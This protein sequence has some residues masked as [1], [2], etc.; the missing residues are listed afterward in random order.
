VISTDPAPSLGDALARP[1]GRSPRKIPLG[2]RWLHAVEIDAPRALEH[3]L[4]ARRDALER[5]AVRGTWL[6][7]EDVSGLLRLS[8]PGI[9]ELAALMEIARLAATGRYDLVVVDTAPTGH[10]LRML[11]MPGTFRAIAGV[12]DAMQAKHRVMVEALRGGWMPDSEDA[13]IAAI[14]REGQDLAALL[15][16]PAKVR[17]SWVTLPEPMAI[18][19]TAD[20]AAALASAGIPLRDIIVNRITPR[21]DRPCGWCDARRVLERRAIGELT[22]RLPGLSLASIAARSTEPRGARA[23]AGIGAELGV[24][25][26]RGAARLTRTPLPGA[27]AATWRSKP[28]GDGG[29]PLDRFMSDG[30]RLILFGGKGGVGKT[31]CAAAVAIAMAVHRP[32]ARVLLMSTDPA[33]SLADVFGSPLSDD[34]R[35]VTAAP[36]NLAAREIDAAARFRDVRD[37]YA[38][39]IDALFERLSRGSSGGVGLDAGHDKEVMQRLID[40]APPGVDELAAVIDVTDALEGGHGRGG[41]DLVVMDTAPSG[42]ALRLLQM[43]ALVQGWARALMSIVLKYQ[44]VAGVGE[45]GAVL[46]K[47]SQGLGRLRALLADPGR[48]SFVAVT[49]GAALPRSETVRLIAGLRRLKVH[50]PA[51]VVNAVG[52]GTCSRCRRAAV[53]EAREIASLCRSAGRSRHVVIAPAE[54]PPPHGVARLRRWQK[55]WRVRVDP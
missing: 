19:E 26:A 41:F 38:A 40:L 7:Q 49:R 28:P 23:L 24:F 25:S 33:H 22:R 27:A 1:L 53:A 55:T 29:V 2:R 9:D 51:I 16:D 35:T 42:H 21:P 39:A 30:T 5:I 31:T 17:L 3:W 12:F 13:L 37:R 43:P 46:L 18:E 8:L 45:L 48:T 32:E 11:S 36:G 20:A 47:L 15:R 10:T 52:R 50:V 44:A 54:L 6:D 34:P 14:D 4:A